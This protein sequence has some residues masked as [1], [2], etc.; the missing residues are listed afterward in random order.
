[1]SFDISFGKCISHIIIVSCHEYDDYPHVP[2]R[3]GCKLKQKTPFSCV[4]FSI[5]APVVR[6]FTRTGVGVKSGMK[7]RPSARR[8]DESM[9]Q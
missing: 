7:A 2:F 9:L 6:L 8:S 1:M 3:I 5:F 4:G